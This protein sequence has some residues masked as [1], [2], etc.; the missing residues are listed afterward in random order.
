VIIDVL[1]AGAEAVM[2]AGAAYDF[3][4]PAG[5]AVESAFILFAGMKVAAIRRAG[6]WRLHV[7]RPMATALWHWLG[8][9]S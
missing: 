1:G 3:A 7:E 2:Q 6:G 8:K 9:L 5:A 4:A